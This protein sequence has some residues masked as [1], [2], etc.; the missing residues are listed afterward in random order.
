MVQES[1][2]PGAA[3]SL[4]DLTF[5]PLGQEYTVAFTSDRLWYIHFTDTND[6][7]VPDKS[8]TWISFYSEK[9]KKVLS[10][11]P[12]TTIIK[13]KAD[14]N[15]ERK[16]RIVNVK[17]KDGAGNVLRSVKF[18]QEYPYVKVEYDNK[19]VNSVD[20]DKDHYIEDISDE[21]DCV[22]S[23]TCN[24][25]WHKDINAE[26]P[27]RNFL[28]VKVTSN[29][30]W[31][32]E[33]IKGSDYFSIVDG[34]KIG[35][36]LLGSK[37]KTFYVSPQKDHTEEDKYDGI[38]KITGYDDPG[39]VD[40]DDEYVKVPEEFEQGTVP[41][42]SISLVQET[43]T[44]IIT[45][46]AGSLND[47]I[48]MSELTQEIANC[49]YVDKAT[50]DIKDIEGLF[51][52]TKIFINSQDKWK[53]DEVLPD[54]L[55]FSKTSGNS[56]KDSFDLFVNKPNASFED[57]DTL[58]LTIK[59]EK[60]DG[61]YAPE[62]LLKVIQ[63]GYQLELIDDESQGIKDS[64]INFKNIYNN[65]PCGGG[66]KTC[67]VKTKGNWSIE[68]SD[69]E[70]D[71]KKD[72]D[73]FE[74]SLKEPNMSLNDPKSAA[75]SITVPDHPEIRRTINV[76]QEKFKFDIK[77]VDEKGV[78]NNSK[79]VQIPSKYTDWN[80]FKVSS[81]GKWE[82]S[83]DGNDSRYFEIEDCENNVFEG[84]G[85][86][87]I[88][89]K[90]KD[91]NLGEGNRNAT[92]TLSSKSH[93][94]KESRSLLLN[95]SK[96]M[97]ELTAESNEIIENL[98]Q[99]PLPAY[100]NEGKDTTTITL[101]LN[102]SGNY[103]AGSDD[104]NVEPDPFDI[105]KQK[106][107]IKI[108]IPI[109]KGKDKKQFNIEIAN[110]DNDIEVLDRSRLSKTIE[111]SQNG[112][113]FNVT[114]DK[115]EYTGLPAYPESNSIATI[116]VVTSN[117]APWYLECPEWIIVEKSD[118]LKFNGSQTITLKLKDNESDKNNNDG[119]REYY[120]IIKS[121]VDKDY[122][123]E[124]RFQQKCLRLHAKAQDNNNL[125]SDKDSRKVFEVT[126]SEGDWDVDYSE[127]E[128]WLRCEKIDD[129]SFRVQSI[130]QNDT[131]KQRSGDISVYAKKN[132]K[133][134]QPIKIIQDAAP[135]K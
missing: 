124:I 103:S 80:E 134:S 90:A 54:W 122:Y 50:D 91:K 116:K 113:E 125:G 39:Y 107:D 69:D 45:P 123:E 16:N 111:M 41:V 93:G 31:K 73:G 36:D 110:E 59:A 14:L 53:I 44:F 15:N 60:E 118:S 7:P 46:P 77:Y 68:D 132:K 106:H 102:T 17:F 121:D 9:E 89:I 95:Q 76:S 5:D 94:G 20:V 13:I 130:S 6:E 33:I 108:Y 42:H 37:N 11:T 75:F 19:N 28:E 65:D 12:G 30:D 92:I 35:K 48:R 2:E 1:M 27:H 57:S 87:T 34:E 115:S 135:K 26:V 55:G 58:M 133:V 62:K 112:F 126:C 117:G 96:Y 32:A 18:T 64:K 88:K 21:W 24:F 25:K 120:V 99:N 114:P 49:M 119:D 4:G 83:L 66:T 84:E 22:Y 63:N 47:E 129:T 56:G 86:K 8:V 128:G 109:N 97:F 131:G 78:E 10:G 38:L 101:Q 51:I 3:I 82:I 105:T 81:S 43:S 71:I 79:E 98:K 23:D 29:I 72:S 85:D 61:S 127:V 74:I 67:K 70:L 104:C 40:K 100:F 52:K